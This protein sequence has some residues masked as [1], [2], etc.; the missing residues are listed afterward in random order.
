MIND[1]LDVRLFHIDHFLFQ[2][3]T[4]KIILSF[5]YNLNEVK[6]IINED[7]INLKNINLLI[8]RWEGREV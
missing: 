5:Q 3:G 8:P 7:K 2:W 6:N 1:S 4:P